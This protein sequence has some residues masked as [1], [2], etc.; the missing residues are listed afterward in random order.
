MS[1]YQLKIKKSFL[2]EIEKKDKYDK[3]EIYKILFSIPEY[4]EIWEEE[5]IEIN[6]NYIFDNIAK[7]EFENLFYNLEDEILQETKNSLSYSFPEIWQ[8]KDFYDIVEEFIKNLKSQL[9][10]NWIYKWKFW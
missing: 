3:K 6:L 1:K 7:V 4:I 10:F 5:K 2:E 8:S 9:W